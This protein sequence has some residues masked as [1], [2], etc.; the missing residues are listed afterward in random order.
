[1]TTARHH[2]IE[3]ALD[4]AWQAAPDHP[5]VG[6]HPEWFAHR[7]D[8]TIRHASNPPKLYQDIYPFDLE[9]PDRDALWSALLEVVRHW[10]D[11]GVR[12]FRVDNPHTKPFDLWEWLIAR[13]HER[14]PDVIFLSEAFTRPKVMHRLAKVGFTQS[15]TYFTWRETKSEI[16]DYFNE[17][18]H[19][20][21][22]TYFRGNVWTNTPDILP[23][24]LQRGS[25][26]TFLARLLLAAGLSSSYGM[27]GPSFELM[28]RDSIAPGSEEYL[29]SEKYQVRHWDFDAPGSLAPFIGHLNRARRAHPALHRNDS[30]RFHHIDNDQIVCWTK[31]CG[32]DRVLGFVSLDAWQVQ[33]GWCGLDL[34]ALGMEPDEAYVVHDLL[35]DAR[36]SWQGARGFV[37]LDPGTVPGHLFE[38]LRE[39]D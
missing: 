7:A 22:S 23:G 24:H 20:P 39:A 1:V 6:E 27:F 29:D 13:V 33:S 30:L 16:I 11:A 8:G 36:Y 12:V 9:G 28:A 4:L 2:G 5:W 32:D 25:R 14:D 3:I 18:A 35:T 37:Q 21:G 34:A 19:G 15:Y 17:L 38:I 10:I 26:A 31:Q